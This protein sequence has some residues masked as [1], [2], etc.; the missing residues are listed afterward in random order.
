MSLASRYDNMRD[1]INECVGYRVLDDDDVLE[2]GD[3]TV[4]GSTLWSGNEE[5]SAMEDEDFASFFGRTVRD[6]NDRKHNDEMDTEERLF[7]RRL[8]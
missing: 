3:E 1:V 4:C 8:K 7:R 6:M 5:W 2:R